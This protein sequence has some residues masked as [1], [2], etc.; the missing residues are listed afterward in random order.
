[1]KNAIFSE[2]RSL[3]KGHRCANVILVLHANSCL[4]SVYIGSCTCARCRGDVVAAMRATMAAI[5]IFSSSVTYKYK[6]KICSCTSIVVFLLIV[7]SL[8]TPL[9]IIY[10][11]G[12]KKFIFRLSRK[13]PLLKSDL[14]RAVYDTSVRFDEF[15]FRRLD[16]KSDARRNAGRTLRIQVLVDR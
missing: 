4:S 2:L 16:E 7:L 11:A 3:C 10:H 9:F 8:L 5:E 12:G 15:V 13:Y 6:S 1:M 14:L